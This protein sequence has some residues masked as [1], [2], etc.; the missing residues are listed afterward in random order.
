M[1]TVII[2]NEEIKDIMEIVKYL[3]ELDL[4]RKVLTKQLNKKNKKVEL[5]PC[6]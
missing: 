2:L 5:L 6:Y 3:E 1:T 4:M